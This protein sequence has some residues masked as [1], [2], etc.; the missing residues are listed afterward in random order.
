MLA[1]LNALG[2]PLANLKRVVSLVAPRLVGTVRLRHVLKIERKQTEQYLKIERKQT[3]QYL[4]MM[5][6]EVE[7]IETRHYSEDEEGASWQLM[8]EVHSGVMSMLFTVHEPY[9]WTRQ[10][11][12]KLVR[13]EGEISF[14][15]GNGHGELSV[16]DGNYVFDVMPSGAGGDVRLEVRVPV[17]IL[18]KKLETEL[19][20][21]HKKGLKF[22]TK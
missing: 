11:W 3:E 21:A 16:E 19:D 10:R 2:S 20:K 8:I 5:Y 13:G 1:S 12:D 6:V 22:A 9:M 14:Y 17:T 18:A 15:Q 4:K 7:A